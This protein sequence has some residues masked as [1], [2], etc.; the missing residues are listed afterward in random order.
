[1]GRMT[2]KPQHEPPDRLKHVFD[3]YGVEPQDTP[4]RTA[5]V[6][7]PTVKQIYII[8]SG[9]HYK[10]GIATNIA[11]RVNAMQTGN[12]IEL[13][14]VASWPPARP[15]EDEAK[16][17]AELAVYRGLREWFELP[18]DIVEQLRERDYGPA[19]TD[20]TTPH[21]GP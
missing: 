8:R 21:D 11:E 10:I 2:D 20:A 4:E 3:W 5:L 14:L 16:L 19:S 7:V 18:P 9:D 12:P 1:M 13:E 15:L 17:H 6:N